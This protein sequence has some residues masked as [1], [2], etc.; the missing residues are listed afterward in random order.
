MHEER[1]E[2]RSFERRLEEDILNRKNVHV[3]EAG[4]FLASVC[5]CVCMHACTRTHKCV[6]VQV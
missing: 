1:V 6:G 4:L 5:V 2:V 3:Q